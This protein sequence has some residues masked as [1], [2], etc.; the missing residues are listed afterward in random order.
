MFTLL[1]EQDVKHVLGG[2][3]VESE[4]WMSGATVDEEVCAICVGIGGNDLAN[5]WG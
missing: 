3:M 1:M 2:H 4:L 5:V